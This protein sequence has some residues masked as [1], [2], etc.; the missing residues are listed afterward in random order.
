MI[1]PAEP[2]RH[3]SVAPQL[4]WHLARQLDSWVMPFRH[5][6]Y[7]RC[8]AVTD[9]WRGC[10]SASAAA[11][12]VR[13][14]GVSESGYHAQRGRAPSDRVVEDKSTPRWVTARRW[15]TKRS[16]RSQ[17][18]S[19]NQK[20]SETLH[21]NGADFTPTDL[22][23]WRAV[24]DRRPAAQVGPFARFPPRTPPRS[25]CEQAGQS[26]PARALATPCKP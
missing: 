26:L 3:R 7:W 5:P 25:H 8:S 6:R 19:R 10:A 16:W 18:G 14:L 12:M 15:H 13:V 1:V 4:R 20:P 24:P 2:R 11:T 21:E 9:R 17:P 23:C 22:G